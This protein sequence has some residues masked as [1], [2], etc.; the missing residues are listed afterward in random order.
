MQSR[1]QS[2]F[3]TVKSCTCGF[4][5]QKVGLAPLVRPNLTVARRQTE[6][7]WDQIVNVGKVVVGRND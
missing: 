4:H 7:N 1:S 2:L 6:V 3:G 5:S